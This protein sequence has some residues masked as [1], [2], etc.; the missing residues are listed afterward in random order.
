MATI[1]DQMIA[2]GA[3]GAGH[4]QPRH[5]LRRGDREE[6]RQA[7][8][9]DHRLR[10]ADP[11]RR[12]VVLRL[13]R[14]RRGRQAAGPGPREVPRA[15]ARPRQHRLPRR[16]ARRTTTPRC[17]SRATTRCWTRVDRTTTWSPSRPCRT[18]T[19]SRPATT[20]SRC[21]TAAGGK[22]DGVLA[23]NDGLADAAHRRS[24]TRSCTAVPV[25]GSG[26]HR[27]GPAEH[28]GRRPVHDGLQGRPTRRPRRWPSSRIALAK[29]QTP[30]D[31]RH[32]QGHHRQP[33]RPAV[34]VTPEAD[35][36]GQ[37]QG[38]HQRRLHQS[39]RLCTGAY[40]AALH[41]AAA[42]C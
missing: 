5:R 29:G 1:A 32:G 23:A 6:G 35:H 36:Q 19:T 16:L 21:Y 18:G 11:R 41:R 40:A 26:R 37:R 28:P 12:R 33:G 15:A 14:Q 9:Q 20:S 30:A 17:S 13:V 34:L 24:R 3:T 27:P 25:T 7:G 22:I 4:R 38:R 31:H 10:P 8:H 2:N 39:R 42:S